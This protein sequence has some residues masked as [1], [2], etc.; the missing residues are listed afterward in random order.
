MIQYEAKR[1][2]LLIDAWN[3]MIAANNVSNILDENTA[4]IGM[5]LTTLNMIRTSVDKFKPVKVIF[6]MDGPQAGERRRKLYNGYKAGRRVKA[7]TSSVKIWDGDD[8][9]G[10]DE[11]TKYT[12]QGAFTYQLEKLYNFLKLLPVTVVIVPYCEGDDL[13]AYLSLKNRED[14]NCIIVSGDQDYCQLIQPGIQVYNWR[15]HV[16]YD[17]K[18]FLEEYHILPQNY[19]IMKMLLGDK[20]DE[21]KGSKGIGK[22]TFEVFY[23]HLSKK[24]LMFENAGAF[25]T[26][27]RNMN[28]EA[29]PTRERNV[30]KKIYT[31][32]D[33]TEHLLLVYRIMKLDED[34]L[35]L[36]HVSSLRAQVEE[37]NGK[38]LSKISVNIAMTRNHFN[39]LYNGFNNDKWLRPFVFV[40]PNVKI[41]V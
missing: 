1:N 22:K 11:F 8:E 6:A 15:K 31:E 4:Q 27:V 14:Y 36:H 21:I 13:I 26:Y 20:S 39:K 18:T 17:E 25:I 32:E 2:I 41:K 10:E 5:F 16:L 38:G 24:E 29:L 12:S 30:I 3:L 9:D 34:V 37:Q 40:T 33:M 35:Q 23:E 7:K 28:L 19:I